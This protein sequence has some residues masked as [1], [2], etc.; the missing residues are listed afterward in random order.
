MF[1]TQ[2]EGSRSVTPDG[3]LAA[4]PVP[5][6]HERSAEARVA[7]VAQTR[8]KF[9]EATVRVVR[10]ALVHMYHEE[11]QAPSQLQSPSGP[12]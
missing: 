9:G 12:E 5:R 6:P 10:M 1:L 3:E 2:S 4:L 8:A 11:G 7:R